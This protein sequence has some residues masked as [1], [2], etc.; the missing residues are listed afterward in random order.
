M[1]EPSPLQPSSAGAA[2][3]LRRDETVLLQRVG[4]GCRWVVVGFVLCASVPLLAGEDERTRAGQAT[5]LAE[6]SLLPARTESKP[7]AAE[8]TRDR[9]GKQAK[10]GKSPAPASAAAADSTAPP[11]PPAMRGQQLYR[12]LLRS[13]AW[14]AINLSGDWEELSWGTGWLLDET[15][16]RVVTNHH[17][18][19]EGA[20]VFKDEQIRVYFP[21]FEGDQL[22]LER[23]QYL[24]RGKA[25]GARVFDSDSQRDLAIL[26]LDDLPA[27]VEPL[28]LA[29]QG[30]QPGESVFQLG[31]PLASDAMW[32]FTSGTVRQVY[33]ARASYR[34]GQVCE[35]LRVETQSPT[36]PGDS[37]GPVIN[38]RGELVAI[39]NG[40]SSAGQ[41]MTYF[42]DASELKS[43]LG[44]LEPLF[45]PQTAEQFNDRGVHYY[46]R[47][48]YERAVADFAEALARD[49]QLA[50]ALNNRG[51]ALSR[52]EDYRTAIA[53]F[54]E[55]IRL[56]DSDADYYQGR[57]LAYLGQEDY[58]LAIADL[59]QAI[60]RA[61]Q[62]AEY[63]G[64][65][66]DVYYARDDHATAIKD[67]SRAIQL[68]PETADYYNSRGVCHAELDDYEAAIKDYSEAIRLAPEEP[69][70]VFN[71]ATANHDRGHD[72]QAA[73]DYARV[74][75]M[76]AEFAEQQQETYERRY[77][78]IANNSSQRITVYL[79]YRTQTTE[80]E[81]EW[82]PA[83]PE[84]DNWLTYTFE[85]GEASYVAHDGFRVNAERVRIWAVNENKSGAWEQYKEADLP[86]A[87]S[88]YK[89]Y[90]MATY[91][92]SFR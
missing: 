34:N 92:Y 86:L 8:R 81:W 32:V 24:K 70:Y 71:R 56:K 38:E 85:P 18:V 23:W 2:R 45:D 15:H 33:R 40:S 22:T 37:G 49:P 69:Q 55:A 30:I 29:E 91:E 58:D 35:F 60:R 80:D 78:K 89:G 31:N 64:D 26:E 87:D 62:A 51:W 53:D 5:V 46:Q 82:F 73:E 27:D 10:D 61:P 63:Y 17:V 66:A 41:L 47:Q 67:Y 44:E 76:D 83:A 68:A 50:D 52:L 7:A 25:F 28:P 88:E 48:R 54:D 59:T 21:E 42:I 19:S 3:D 90:F 6:P 1:N 20:S 39:H 75:Q 65:R 72:E 11:A 77:L 16:R 57:G 36:N 74:E 9:R 14:I 84:E 4:V 13:T 12:R 43:Y 79:K